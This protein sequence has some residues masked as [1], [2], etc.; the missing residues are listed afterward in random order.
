MFILL[1]TREVQIK[2]AVARHFSLMT[3]ATVKENQCVNVSCSDDNFFLLVCLSIMR[4]LEI[5]L[6]SLGLV[7]AGGNA[8]VGAGVESS[9]PCSTASSLSAS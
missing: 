1:L 3:M 9:W 8:S 6:W 4:V 5:K 7:A 2:I